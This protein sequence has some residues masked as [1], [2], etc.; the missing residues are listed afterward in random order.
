MC[1]LIVEIRSKEGKSY[2]IGVVGVKSQC[3]FIIELLTFN[4]SNS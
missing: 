4:S 1:L 3:F 2:F